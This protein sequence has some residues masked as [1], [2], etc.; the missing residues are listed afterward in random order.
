VAVFEFIPFFEVLIVTTIIANVVSGAP[1][2]FADFV[3]IFFR[4][5]LPLWKKVYHFPI[6]SFK[7]VAVCLTEVCPCVIF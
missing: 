7:K 4:Q 2:L 6:V 5:A 1:D 3:L